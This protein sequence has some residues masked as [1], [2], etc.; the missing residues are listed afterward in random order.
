MFDLNV[1]MVQAGEVNITAFPAQLQ[2][3]LMLSSLWVAE[4]LASIILI[5]VILIPVIIFSREPI[6]PL[7]V[8]YLGIFLCTALGWLDGWIVIT[9]VLIASGLWSFGLIQKMVGG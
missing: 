6:L 1:L 5:M 9:L 4:L 3:K 7:C 2:V 8:G